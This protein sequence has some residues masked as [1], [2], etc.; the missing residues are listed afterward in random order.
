MTTPIPLPI[1]LLGAVA[2]ILVI[3]VAYRIGQ[4]LLRVFVGLVALALLSWV[5]WKLFL[6]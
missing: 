3:Y 2:V 5:L 6:A 4:V 1:L